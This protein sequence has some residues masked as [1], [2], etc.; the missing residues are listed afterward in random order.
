MVSFRAPAVC[1]TAILLPSMAAAQADLPCDSY[2]KSA[3]VFVGTAGDVVKRIVQLPG[4]PPLEM[5]L[6]PMEVER[7]YLGVTTSVMYV[8]PL[9]VETYATPGQRYV[10]YGRSYHPRSH[11]PRRL[12]LVSEPMYV[13]Q[14]CTPGVNVRLAMWI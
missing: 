3:A 6:T 8:M 9:G 4:H 13:S 2:S 12:A 14:A 10:V 7:A 5:K 1:L 11:R